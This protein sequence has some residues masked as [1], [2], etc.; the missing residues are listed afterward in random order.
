[1]LNQ[2]GTDGS[3][4]KVATGNAS[5]GG[6]V[7]GNL[8]VATKKSKADEQGEVPLRSLEAW[9]H[10]RDYLDSCA[11]TSSGEDGGAVLQEDDDGDFDELFEVIGILKGILPEPDTN[12]GEGL[13]RVDD[14]EKERP[15]IMSAQDVS[16]EFRTMSTIKGLL[17]VLIS[18]S[19]LHVG[20]HAIS[21]VLEEEQG[22]D[23]SIFSRRPEE[24][25][26]LSL[27]Y[28]PYNAAAAS[29]LANYLRMNMLAPVDHICNLYMLA[30]NNASKMRSLAISLLDNET[31]DEEVKEWIE[32]LL[33]NGIAGSEFADPE[34]GQEEEDSGDK[35]GNG[36]DQEEEEEEEEE[37][38]DSEVEATASF[39][40]SL[41]NSIQGKHEEALKYQ[42][43]FGI[44]HRIHPNVWSG[45]KLSA[46]DVVAK[47]AGDLPVPVPA[48]FRS[49]IDGN[50]VLP[51]KQ[52]KGLCDV[53]S[54]TSPY[55][56]ESDY[57]N[58]GYYSYFL[59]L[60]D[61][62]R[63]SPKNII[64]DVIVN[65][66][67]PLAKRGLSAEE[68]EKICGAEW[69]THHRPIEA[70]LGHQ[71]HFDTDEALLAQEQAVTHPIL[72]SVL[73][74]RGGSTGHAVSPAGSTI[75]F[76]QTPDSEQVASK[77]WTSQPRNN[78]FMIFPG[79]L[80]HGV[81]P[82][83]GDEASAPQ[84]SLEQPEHRLTFMVGFWTR[85]VPD[86]MTDRRLYGPC[87]P[88][89]PS[90]G[91]HTWVQN[92]ATGYGSGCNSA[93]SSGRAE[94]VSFALPEISPAWECLDKDGNRNIDS[95]GRCLEIPRGLDHRFFVQN[96][97]YCFRDS[98]MNKDESF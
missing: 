10:Y 51:E 37:V 50:G 87:G 70:N 47:T 53:F 91:D 7:V 52:Y 16:A 79:D 23:G 74:L 24:Y 68:G 31:V 78:T 28:F 73:Y 34:D 85:R 30:A 94:I 65:Y 25:L 60:T 62:M 14:L 40:A 45:A 95:D 83:P 57:D 59:D 61:D 88:L 20:S 97:P 27:Q 17:P 38:T 56:R 71:L 8:P 76:D 64:E 1:M 63:N 11:C 4:R 29:M 80:L 26:A 72:S 2:R 6:R 22:G 21:L 44:T 42:K 66:L 13:L 18:M 90:T 35:E 84:S 39:M 49:T 93:A 92:I 55:W 67:L 32:L 98:L 43:K 75:V 86:K 41:L 48:S 3:K 82:C 46:N 81:L 89:P 9:G 36:K 58:R 5:T 77:V 15:S 96:A 12:T 19:Y 54:P 69:W 33:L